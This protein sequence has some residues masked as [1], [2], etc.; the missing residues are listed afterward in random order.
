MN[1]AIIPARGGSQRIPRK[2]I[3][4]FHGKPII[5]YSIKVARDSRY[6]DVVYVST[7]DPEIA[8]ISIAHGAAVLYR[9]AKLAVDEIGTQEVMA[10]ALRQLPPVFENACCI[11]PCAPL[12]HGGD[13]ARAMELLWGENNKTKY[14]VP[15][16]NWLK[17]EGQ[18]YAG[19]ASAFLQNLQ[20]LS[21]H[22]AILPIDKNRAI[23]INCMDDWTTAEKMYSMLHA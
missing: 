4:M 20:L 3:K 18:F 13:I 11:Y 19:K 5:A 23:D 8:E 17:D 9:S 15:V 16:A 14:V 12:I 2:N 1:V 10:D 21:S 6:I 7:E 22:T